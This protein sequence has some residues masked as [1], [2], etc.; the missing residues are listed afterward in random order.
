MEIVR[1][2]KCPHW[3]TVTLWLIFQKYSIIAVRSAVVENESTLFD[4][5]YSRINS[6]WKSQTHF[7]TQSSFPPNWKTAC[8]EFNRKQDVSVKSHA[9]PTRS[10]ALA[11][12][13][14]RV[15]ATWSRMQTHHPLISLISENKQTSWLKSP[16]RDLAVPQFSLAQAEPASIPARRWAPLSCAAETEWGS[17]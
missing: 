3:Y 6:Y 13:G 4:Q 17:V 1:H 12:P 15:E 8:Y 2:A 14:L 10:L 7:N 16:A 5:S 9:E 11:T